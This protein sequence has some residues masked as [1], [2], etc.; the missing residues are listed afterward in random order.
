MCTLDRLEETGVMK[1]LTYA[2]AAAS[3]ITT[4]RGALCGMPTLDE[5]ENLIKN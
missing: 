5:I 4:R 3:L 1:M 2:N